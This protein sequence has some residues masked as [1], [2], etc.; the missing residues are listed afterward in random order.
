MKRHVI[1]PYQPIINNES[2][3]L[4]LGTVPS[5]KSIENGFYYGHPQNRFWKVLSSLLNVDLLSLNNDLKQN[6]LL[7]HYIALYDVVYSC[8]IEGSDDNK[9]TNVIP[10]NLE[11][12]IDESRISHIFLN[13]KT[14]YKIFKKYFPSYLENVTVLPSTSPRNASYSLERLIEHW[15]T[16]LNFCK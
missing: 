9:I 13:G 5:I 15:K 12:L 3:V 14:C 8:E 2:R 10:I 11:K 7:D 16:I 6:C 1:H 4:I